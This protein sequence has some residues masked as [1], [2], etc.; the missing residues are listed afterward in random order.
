MLLLNICRIFIY[1]FSVFDMLVDIE[2]RNLGINQFLHIFPF[3][4]NGYTKVAA[5]IDNTIYLKSG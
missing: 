1:S 5:A 3:Y 4:G 2:L